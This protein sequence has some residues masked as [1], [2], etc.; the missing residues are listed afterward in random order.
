MDG[1]F[2]ATIVRK[3]QCRFEKVPTETPYR[4]VIWPGHPGT[5]HGGAT[6]DGRSRQPDEVA[7]C[8]VFLASEDASYISGQGLRPDGAVVRS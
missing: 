2:P 1:Y 5:K 6:P 4:W 7:R 8:S 3:Q